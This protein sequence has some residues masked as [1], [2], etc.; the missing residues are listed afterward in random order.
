MVHLTSDAAIMYGLAL[1]SAMLA[2][3]LYLSHQ[4][5]GGVRHTLIWA[6][7]FALGTIQWALIAGY[8]SFW[9]MTDPAFLGSTWAGG[10]VALLLCVGFRERAGLPRRLGWMIA[11]ALISLAAVVLPYYVITRY[12]QVTLATPQIMR[13]LFALLA[14]ATLLRHR[15]RREGGH[16]RKPAGVEAMAAVLLI[17]LAIL[18]AVIGYLRLIDCGCETNAGRVV[19]LV[20]LPV[21]YSGTGIACVLLLTSDLSTQLHRIARTD[22]LTQVLNRRGF[23][24]AA[25]AALIEAARRKQPACV[26]QF[27]LDH[28]KTINDNFGHGEGD[29]VLRAVAACARSL[30]R[31]SDVL[32]RLGGEEFV[33]V[34]PGL[35]AQG[36]LMR[37]ERLRSAIAALDVLPM[38]TRISASF[39]IASVEQG[40]ED[41]TEA[42][43]GALDAADRALY[44]AKEA[45]RNR[46]CLAG[47]APGQNSGEAPEP[48]ILRSLRTLPERLNA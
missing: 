3:G 33:M 28:F 10:L 43:E 46:S 8:N 19:L 2:C 31:E 4:M 38:G 30:Q 32:A 11:A 1:I 37:A 12:G 14:A 40:A 35:D 21:L 20:G 44:R 22:P 41:V 39:G 17:A 24:E 48:A 9:D 16:W 13:T 36:A 25:S 47:I 15:D 42:L 27:D 23:T 29:A 5:L 45:G 6:T 34:I 18:S 7:A 26:I